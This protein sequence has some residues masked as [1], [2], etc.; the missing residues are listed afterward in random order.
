MVN[1][2]SELRRHGVRHQQGRSLC[3]REGERGMSG[4]VLCTS[5]SRGK[6]LG[7]EVVLTCEAPCLTVSVTGLSIS[8]IASPIIAVAAGVVTPIASVLRVGDVRFVWSI[9]K[10]PTIIP[11]PK[12]IEITS[13]RGIPVPAVVSVITTSA[14]P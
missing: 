8:I 3:L 7:L 13:S 1:L 9:V 2:L 14:S 11:V 6:L 10:P 5:L 12:T 4:T